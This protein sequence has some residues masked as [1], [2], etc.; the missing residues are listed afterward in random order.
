MIKK[1]IGS[2]WRVTRNYEMKEENIDKYR[3]GLV[4]FGLVWRIK[5]EM[6]NPFLYI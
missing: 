2:V 6:P 4:W 1:T 5:Q 3:L